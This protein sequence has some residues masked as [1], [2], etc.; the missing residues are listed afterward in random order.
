MVLFRRIFYLCPCRL[1]DIDNMKQ[2]LLFLFFSIFAPISAQYSPDLLGDGYEARTI[3]M[4]DDYEG[5]VV[6]TLVKKELE[7]QNDTHRAIL[8]VHGYN[9]YFFQSQLGDSCLAHGYNFY[10]LDLRKYGRSLLPHQDAFFCKDLKEYFADIDTAL[11]AIHEEGNREIV[12]MAHST[13]GLITSYYLSQRP[14]E[15]ASALILNSP[16]LDWNF[17]WF[18]ENILI[19]AVSATGRLFP[20]L[21]VQGE[22]TSSYARSLLKVFKGEWMFNTDWKMPNGHPKR[23]GWIRA[24]HEA[25]NY[26]QKKANIPCPVLVLSSDRSYPESAAWHDE[27]LISDIVLYVNDIQHYGARLGEK[28]VCRQIPCGMHDLILSRKEARDET[29][30]VI[31]EFL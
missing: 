18:M 6:C 4:P 16:F 15:T 8:Y 22:N 7:P 21:T 2:L 10:A 13:G 25:Q 12:F 19:P 30:K 9:D 11:V 31:F 17:G 5:R 14:P 23:A 26:V 24:I 3:Q 29:Y 20:E 27:Y 1:S 28:V